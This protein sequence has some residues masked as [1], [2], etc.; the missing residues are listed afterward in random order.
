DGRS[1][2]RWFYRSAYVDNAH[3]VS[4]LSLSSPPV[5]LHDVVPPRTPVVTRVLGG[6]RAVTIE[7]AP[8]REPDLAE[9]RILRAADEQSALDPRTMTVVHTETVADVAAQPSGLSWTDSPLPGLTTF[10]YRL[11]SVDANGNVSDPSPVVLGRAHDEAL[12]AVPAL[13]LAWSAG[14]APADAAVSWT[15]PEDETMLELRPVG[16]PVWRAAGGWQPSGSPA[17]TLELDATLDWQFRLQ[18]RKYTGAVA[19]GAAQ[20]LEGLP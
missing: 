19:V 15:A 13:T 2:K 14:A 1:S 4:G 9:Y 12:P 20:T 18:V 8:S 17:L 10:R 7:W 3:N 11:V 6:D 16:Q 5:Y